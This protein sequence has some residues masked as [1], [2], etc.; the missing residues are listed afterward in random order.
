[1]AILGWIKQLEGLNA[2]LQDIG[3]GDETPFATK[4][5]AHFLKSRFRVLAAIQL[6]QPMVMVL[7]VSS[8]VCVV[9]GGLLAKGEAAGG[10][11]FA[12]EVI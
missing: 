11:D 1:M 10:D 7:L 4:Y 12:G 5:R 8:A 2:A 6:F 3:K 9:S